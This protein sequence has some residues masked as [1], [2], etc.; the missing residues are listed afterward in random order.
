VVDTARLHVAALLDPSVNGQRIF[1]LVQE[2]NW[3]D[4][5]R[6]LRKLRPEL[7]LPK[8]PESEGRDLTEVVP[9]AKAEKL[10]QDFFGQPGW[11][12]LEDSLK[13][14]IEDL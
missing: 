13:A 2:F 3:T 9:K 10:L 14:G 7:E 4:V 12:S 8:D 6:I 1:G 5:L 11:T